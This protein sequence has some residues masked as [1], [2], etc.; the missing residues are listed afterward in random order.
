MLLKFDR[1]NSRLT[2]VSKELKIAIKG[3]FVIFI[4]INSY[5]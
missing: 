2:L 4:F 5:Q 3:G 1:D